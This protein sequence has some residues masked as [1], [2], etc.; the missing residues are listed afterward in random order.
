M[1]TSALPLGCVT[2]ADVGIGPYEVL[3]RLSQASA[4]REALAWLNR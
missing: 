3:Y 1:P 2:R 4:S